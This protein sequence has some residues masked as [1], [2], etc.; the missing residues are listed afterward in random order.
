MKVIK[1]L[2]EDQFIVETEGFQNTVREIKVNHDFIEFYGNGIIRSDVDVK[3]GCMT[4][5]SLYDSGVSIQIPIR[6]VITM[7]LPHLNNHEYCQEQHLLNPDGSPNYTYTK[8]T[9]G[10]YDVTKKC[11]MVAIRLKGETA[12]SHV[13]LEFYNKFIKNN[14]I[15]E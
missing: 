9:I 3:Q 15:N 2:S 1:Q 4:S 11:H 14:L 8:S 7:I 12:Y 5:R 6:D 10:Y 13:T